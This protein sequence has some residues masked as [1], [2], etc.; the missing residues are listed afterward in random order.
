MTEPQITFTMACRKF[1]D[2]KPG[3]TLLQFAQ[4]IK[5][6]GEQ[7]RLELAPLL[8]VALGMAVTL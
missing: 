5:A 7:D 1:F 2:V 4:E 8:S 6:L 3:Q